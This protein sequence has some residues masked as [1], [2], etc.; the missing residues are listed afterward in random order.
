MVSLPTKELEKFD[1]SKTARILKLFNKIKNNKG[2]KTNKTIKNFLIL[3]I[4]YL[5]LDSEEFDDMLTILDIEATQTNYRNICKQ[6][7]LYIYIKKTDKNF[8]F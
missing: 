4:T 3:E 2:F 5:F 7:W 6:C 1:E 8:K